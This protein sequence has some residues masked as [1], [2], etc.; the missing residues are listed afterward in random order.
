MADTPKDRRYTTSHEWVL[1]EGSLIVIGI[2][3]H[4]VQELSDLVFIDLPE[5]GVDAT[6]GEPFGEIESVKAVSEL[7]SP[8]TG[9]IVEVNKEIEDNLDTIVES[10]YD[11]GWLIKVDPTEPQE[12]DKLLKHEEY[13]KHVDGS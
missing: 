7:N 8:V 10:P 6:A 9:T 11:E 2:T 1:K 5:A 3:D 13:L 4:A 12:Y